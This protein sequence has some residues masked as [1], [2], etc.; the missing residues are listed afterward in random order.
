[1]PY[2][3]AA[4]RRLIIHADDLGLSPAIS[5]GILKAIAEGVVTSTSLLCNFPES[6]GA[7]TAAL[8][9][10]RD[11]G[12]HL[13]LVQGRPLTPPEQIP[14]LVNRDGHFHSLRGLMYRSLRGKL[15]PSQ[16]KRELEAQYRV[17]SESGV[18]P[19]H[20]DGHLHTQIFPGIRE[21]IK[22]LL[23]EKAIPFIRAPQELGS[24]LEPRWSARTFLNSFRGCRPEY[25]RDSG[26][27]ALPFFGLALSGAP[28]QA[29]L[30][31]QQLTRNPHPLAECMVHPGHFD[32][33]EIPLLGKMGTS[34]EA[35]LRWLT[36]PT[37]RKLLRDLQYELVNFTALKKNN[38][39][40]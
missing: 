28:G 18:R 26:A 4:T 39:N 2:P 19:S 36:S 23:R 6:H 40:I 38:K 9:A 25:W 32:S 8:E 27:E 11:V 3:M 20:V 33:A 16:I 31:E 37:L 29:K 10:G 7:L 35:E 12:W 21:V 14:S 22:V 17:F 24:P 34:R 13:N 1:M 30:W 15:A 5:R